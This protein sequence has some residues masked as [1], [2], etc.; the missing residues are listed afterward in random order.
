MHNV[1]RCE[2]LQYSSPYGPLHPM[3]VLRMLVASSARRIALEDPCQKRRSIMAPS[4]ESTLAMR[5]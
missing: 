1:I 3:W 5:A 4:V 2:M